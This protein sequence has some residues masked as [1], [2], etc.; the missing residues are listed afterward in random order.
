MIVPYTNLLI[1]DI[2]RLDLVTINK[3]E[4]NGFWYLN[5]SKYHVAERSWHKGKNL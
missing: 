2:S 5:Y 4:F 3:S 1:S